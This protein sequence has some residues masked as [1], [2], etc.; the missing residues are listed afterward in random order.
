MKHS[1][2]LLALTSVAVGW[3]LSYPLLKIIGA[4]MAPFS[5]ITCRFFL[6][7]ILMLV[8]FHKKLK[9]PTL[10]LLNTSFLG[11]VQIVAMVLFILYAVKTADASTVGFLISSSVAFVIII[12][13]FITRTLPSLS[14]TGALI[15]ILCGLYLLSGSGG[16][17]FNLGA[18]FALLSGLVYAIDIH[19]TRVFSQRF[20]AV[21]FGFWQVVFSTLLAIIA[22]TITGEGF[23]LPSSGHAI[24]SLIAL[25]V[26]CTF[27]C[28][29]MQITAQKYTTAQETGLVFTLEPVSS[30]V[31]A[32]FILDENMS[33]R[34]IIG[35]LIV[36]TGVIC[37]LLLSNRQKD[38][39]L[40]QAKKLQI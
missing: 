10:P 40:A 14:V 18:A 26:I 4:E 39:H 35:A 29:Y 27:Y 8:F 30:A 34:S 5:V 11:A 28:F 15:V 36:L 13:I 37:C 17:D 19:F 21:N 32:W 38:K 25:S 12:N 24:V 22:Q 23:A 3:G 20:N 1:T 2:A 16:L 31:Y 33:S 9:K 6:T 7:I